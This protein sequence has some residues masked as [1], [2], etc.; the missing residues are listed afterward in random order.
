MLLDNCSHSERKGNGNPQ[1]L[2]LQQLVWTK[3]DLY[4][5]SCSEVQL[6]LQLNAS[7][8]CPSL[9]MSR[10]ARVWSGLCHD[11]RR[12]GVLESVRDEILVDP[13]SRVLASRQMADW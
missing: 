6:C 11:S 5:Y 1:Q 4:Y 10:D 12:N 7:L 9:D 8:F 2:K 3:E 13:H